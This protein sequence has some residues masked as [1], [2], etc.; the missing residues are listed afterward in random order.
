MFGAGQAA[1]P[2]GA[3][4]IERE[5]AMIEYWEPKPSEQSSAGVN[6]QVVDY[7]RRSYLGVMI[8]YFSMIGLFTG[9]AIHNL[10]RGMPVSLAIFFWLFSVLPLL[11]FLPGLRQHNV[12]THAWLSFVI[13]LYFAHAVSVAFTAG[14][15]FYGVVF[16]LLCTALFCAL[17]IHIRTA[18]KHLGL[19]L[20]QH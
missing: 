20:L 9:K 16:C 18:R 19:S 17:V 4:I 12:R 2:S 1:G 13:L 10:I 6:R 14:S 7:V 8:S 3:A 15:L 5:P 11:I